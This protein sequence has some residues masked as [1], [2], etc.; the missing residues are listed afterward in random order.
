MDEVINSNLAPK[1]HIATIN[2][3]RIYMRQTLI[4]EATTTYK[5]KLLKYFDNQEGGIERR[6]RGGDFGYFR[7]KSNLSLKEG[8]KKS[9]LDLLKSIEEYTGEEIIEY[10]L[11]PNDYSVILEDTTDINSDWGK[12]LKDYKKE[13]GDELKY[14]A[15]NEAWVERAS[16]GL[17]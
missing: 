16:P 11:S 2:W 14:Q 5:N 13:N 15:F 1:E 7:S 12:L 8:F 17:A 3:C 10:E 6:I 9:I 4:S